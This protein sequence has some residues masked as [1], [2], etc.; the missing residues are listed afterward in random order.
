MPQGME[1]ITVPFIAVHTGI[2]TQCPIGPF[3]PLLCVLFL[4]PNPFNP[5]MSLMTLETAI[6]LKACSTQVGRKWERNAFG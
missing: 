1:L 5:F 4:Q 2:T 3:R 6:W